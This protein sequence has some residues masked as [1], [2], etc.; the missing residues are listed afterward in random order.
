MPA[1]GHGAEE[2]GAGRYALL[3][4]SFQ[5]VSSFGRSDNPLSSTKVRS[6]AREAVLDGHVH[7]LTLRTSLKTADPTFSGEKA[8]IGLGLASTCAYK[9][10]D[11]LF[12]L[13]LCC[14]FWVFQQ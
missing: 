3:L 11:F 7:C 1:L 4:E 8:F 10:Q 2:K 13:D 12:N 9:H 5:S 14:L 6:C